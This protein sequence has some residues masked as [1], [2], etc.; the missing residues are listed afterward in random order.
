M[1]IRISPGFTIIET[2]LFLAVTGLL[3]MGVLIG[4]G[5]TLN[6]QRYRDSVESFKNLLQSQYADL[7]S[8]RNDRSNTWNCDSTA[9]PIVGGTVIRGQSDCVIVGKYLRIDKGDVTI[10]TVLARK[11]GTGTG[12]DIQK[13]DA[14]YAYNVSSAEVEKRSMEWGAQIAWPKSGMGAQSPTTPRTLGIFIVRSPDS[15]S[16]YTFTSNSVPAVDSVNQATFTSIIAAGTGIP[17]QGE[18]R[19]CVVSSGLSPSGDMAIVIGGY[20]ASTSAIEVQ[21]NDFM[22]S[23]GGSPQC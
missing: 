20:A 4:T 1:G 12:T 21:S 8:V 11:T 5:N 2:M 18:R 6:T 10:H 23:V 7:G 13:L 3:I 19:I 16:I 14:N 22:K 9:K 15:G 17:G